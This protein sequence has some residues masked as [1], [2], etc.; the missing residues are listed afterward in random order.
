MLKVVRWCVPLTGLK[1]IFKFIF[2]GKKHSF[3]PF[4][5]PVFRFLSSLKSG[6]SN[7]KIRFYCLIAPF[8]NTKNAKSRF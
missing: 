1:S 7:G 8:P 2:T 6:F 3:L 4:S 5:F